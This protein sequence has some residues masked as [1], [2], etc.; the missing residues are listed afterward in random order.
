[1][2]IPPTAAPIKPNLRAEAARVVAQVMGGRSLDDALAVAKRRVEEARDQALMQRIAYGVLRHHTRLTR[3]AASML[4]KPLHNEAEMQALLAVGLYQLSAMRVPAHAAIAET[5]EATVYLGRAQFRGLV[6]ALLRRYQ[7]EGEALEAQ[8]PGDIQTQLS[9]PNWLIQAVKRDWPRKW[10]AVLAAG[11]EPGPLSL[12][13][14]ARRT[15]RESL[16]ERLLAAEL[17]AEAPE[18]L[19]DALVLSEAVNVDRIPGFAEGEVSV[20]DLSAQ[21]A[22]LLMDVQ[23]GQRVLDACAAPGGKAAHLL[24]RADIDLLAL[25]SDPARLAKVEET[26]A[27]LGLHAQL[28]CADAARAKDRLEAKLFDRI[29][30]DAPCSGTGV[31]RRHPDIK[32][33]RRADDIPRL[34]DGQLKL[35]QAL[36]PLLAPGGQLLYA[37][38]SILAEEGEHI[39]KR[40]LMVQADAKHKPIE[41]DWGETCRFGRRIPP[42]GAYDGFYYA[43]F[44]KPP[45]R[46]SFI[47]VN[48]GGS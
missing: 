22:G 27:R 30:L 6:N 42:G 43:A 10:E 17:V 1:M 46:V 31:I 2:S 45:A 13:V 14:N 34:A 29:L 19:P 3:L 9:Y 48:A 28:Q 24:E 37:T 47:P 11:N 41:A 32:W 23:A 26:L 39:A 5:V 16:R 40:F 8:L 44:V 36:W 7:R 35:L 20:Q 33:L 21:L 4:Q 25:D 15:T 18:A 38:C 12:R